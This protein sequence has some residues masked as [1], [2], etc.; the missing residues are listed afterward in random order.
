MYVVSVSLG[1]QKSIFFCRVLAHFWP[2]HQHALYAQ[3]P[4]PHTLHTLQTQAPDNT[5]IQE[6]YI[7]A[8]INRPHS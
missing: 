8:L 5:H 6:I 7:N 4:S 1:L 3:A 2:K